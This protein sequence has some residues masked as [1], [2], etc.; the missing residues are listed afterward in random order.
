LIKTNYH[1]IIIAQISETQILLLL[2]LAVFLTFT[3]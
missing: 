3:C 2:L 1:I